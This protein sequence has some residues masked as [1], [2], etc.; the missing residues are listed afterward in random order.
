MHFQLKQFICNHPKIHLWFC[1]Q[2]KISSLNA[3]YAFNAQLLNSVLR[4]KRNAWCIAAATLL[5]ST[6]NH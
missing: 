6:R 5:P 1:M 2:G 4:V 3:V